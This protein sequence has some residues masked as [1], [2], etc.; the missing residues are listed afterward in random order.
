MNDSR[1]KDRKNRIIRRQL[2]EIES[3]KEKISSLEISCN[4]KDDIINS[5]DSL[6]SE[7]TDVIA[8]LK[9]KGKEYDALIADVRKM[10][11]VID[12]EVFKNRWNLIKLLIR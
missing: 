1:S 12:E 10:K 6:R 8:D 9:K 4:E 7:L 11:K 2:D 5:I 3:L